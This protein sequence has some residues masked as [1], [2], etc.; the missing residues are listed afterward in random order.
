MRWIVSVLIAFVVLVAILLLRLSTMNMSAIAP[1][2]METAA[3]TRMKY[4]HIG[5]RTD[6]N[7]SPDTPGTVKEGA[8]HFQHHCE[9]CHGLDGQNT[10]VP[11]AMNLAPPVADLASERVQRYTDGQL[12][13]IIENGIRFT[14]MPGWKGI[15]SDE[16]AWNIVRYLRHLPPKGS[17]GAP[18]VF[19]EA[20]E[21]HEHGATTEHE[22]GGAAEHQPGAPVGQPQK[23]QH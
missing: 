7:P 22:H 15:L 2:G 12:K 13:W 20:K 21:E 8:E 10:G 16:E 9:V 5:G 1:G 6:K 11:F 23:H 18:A 3:V 4:A 17:L 19:K 14:G